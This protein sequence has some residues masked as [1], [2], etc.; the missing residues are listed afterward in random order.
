MKQGCCQACGLYRPLDD[1]HIKTR[2]A[3]P[4]L[5]DKKW[6]IMKLCRKCH[7]LQHQIGIITFFRKFPH[8]W[9]SLFALGWK[10]NE[11]N[12]LYFTGKDEGVSHELENS[13]FDSEQF[14]DD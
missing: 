8:L 7:Q 5:K 3:W 14:T 10:V 9:D 13:S 12:Q 4:D 1:A 2:K 11:Y 6:N